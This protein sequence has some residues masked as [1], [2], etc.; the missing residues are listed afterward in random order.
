MGKN[1]QRSSTPRASGSMTPTLVPQQETG[2]AEENVG[3]VIQP[4]AEEIEHEHTEMQLESSVP[5]T[6]FTSSGVKRGPEVPAEVLADESRD[7]ANV[8]AII[9][10]R[11]V[12][13]VM[14]YFPDEPE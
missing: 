3:D 7:E 12:G 6:V 2:H 1:E 14:T 8:G 9:T 10:E 13:E 11:Q 5:V 4:L